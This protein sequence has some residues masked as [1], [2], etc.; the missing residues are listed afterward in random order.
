MIIVK[1]KPRLAAI[2]TLYD[3]FDNLLDITEFNANCHDDIL[4]GHDIN[5]ILGLNE[6]F[7]IRNHILSR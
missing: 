6:N 7:R 2:E 1:T 5:Y 3:Y 4:I